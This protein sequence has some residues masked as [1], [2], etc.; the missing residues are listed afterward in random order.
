[1]RPAQPEDLDIVLKLARTVHFIN[2]PADK[3]IIA[4]KFARSLESFRAAAAGKR[5]VAADA[6]DHSATAGSPIFMFVIADSETN[7]CIGTSMI[8]AKMGT[9]GHPNVSYELSKREFFSKDLQSGATH[10]VARLFLDTSGKSEIGGLIL[11]PSMRKNPEKL[12]KQLSLIRFHF[13]GAH[14][15]QF[16]DRLLAEMMAPISAD[17]RTASRR[18]LSHPAASGG[19]SGDRAGRQGHGAGPQDARSARLQVLR[20]DRSLRWGSASRGEHRRH[21]S[22]ALHGEMHIYWNVH[23]QRGQAR[24]LHQRRERSRQLQGRA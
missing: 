4:E 15:E 12:G 24:G 19:S 20:A 6:S 1:M 18:Y 23:L 3:D 11:G 10:T 13:M 9:P 14:R 2:L 7:T 17:G 16:S 21:L 22:C 8:I 5:E